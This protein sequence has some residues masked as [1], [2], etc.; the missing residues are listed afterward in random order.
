MKD[1]TRKALPFGPL[2]NRQLIKSKKINKIKE[3]V[4]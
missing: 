2:I 1:I 4:D 3:M